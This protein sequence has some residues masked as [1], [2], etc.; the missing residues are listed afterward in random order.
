MVKVEESLQIGKKFIDVEDGCA[1]STFA[2]DQAVIR[3]VDF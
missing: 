2:H 1:G 3:I